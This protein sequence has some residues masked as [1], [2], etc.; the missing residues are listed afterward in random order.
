MQA[1]RYG[2]FSVRAMAVTPETEFTLVNELTPFWED[3]YS[4]ALKSADAS[5]ALSAEDSKTGKKGSAAIKLTVLENGRLT[6]D[7]LAKYLD[8]TPLLRWINP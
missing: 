1:N 7:D 8:T 5:F 3:R 4:I 2:R 6:I